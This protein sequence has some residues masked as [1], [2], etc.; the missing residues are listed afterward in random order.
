MRNREIEIF[1]MTWLTMWVGE[2]LE[3]K[4]DQYLVKFP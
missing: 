4:R 1:N 3:T 2:L